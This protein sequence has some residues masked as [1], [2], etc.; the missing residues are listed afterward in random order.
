MKCPKCDYKWCWI[1]GKDY[2]SSNHIAFGCYLGRNLLDFYWHTI[3]F[4]ILFPIALAFSPLVLLIYQIEIANSHT[5]EEPRI[6][7]YKIFLYVLSSILSPHGH[8]G[9]LAI[10]VITYSLMFQRVRKLLEL[11]KC[12]GFRILPVNLFGQNS[13]S[14][15]VA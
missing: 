3:I 5:I 7:R 11:Q 14:G 8:L 13:S 6:R 1:C 2:T 15:D 12:F 9:I 4:F 10:P